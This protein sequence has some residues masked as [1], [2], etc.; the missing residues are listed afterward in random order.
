MNSQHGTFNT[1]VCIFIF[2]REKQTL[3][4]IDIIRKVR[5]LKM[6]IV[7]E[8]HRPNKPGEE[9]KVLALRC[10]VEAA[11]DWEC[12]VKTNYVP[13]D[14]GAGKRIFTGIN[15]VFEH[16]DRCIFLE[17]DIRPSASFFYFCANLLDYYKHDNRI[18]LI[19]GFNPLESYDFG[20]ASYGF[21]HCG[22]IY[23]WATWKNR[24]DKY[25]WN[26]DGLE[27]N[28]INLI[29]Q[30]TGNSRL[31]GKR[32]VNKWEKSRKLI[33]NKSISTWDYQWDITRRMN[34]WL[35][36]VPSVSLTENCG[37]DE[38]AR[39]G[40]TQLKFMPRRIRKIFSVNKCEISFPLIHPSNFLRDSTYDDAYMRRLLPN[41]VVILSDIITKKVKKI[42]FKI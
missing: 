21:S 31:L 20:S 4:L 42:F 8:G 15:W 27:T 28:T 41:K 30:M 9:E 33:L 5:P 2:L 19:T 34:N 7:G 13:K 12:E 25:D 3:E 11:I 6:Y 1:P 35:D 36:V 17:D 39:S 24:W 10:K 18:G 22:S 32:R 23:G 16:E 37:V 29:S 26:M 14:I 38:V 40:P